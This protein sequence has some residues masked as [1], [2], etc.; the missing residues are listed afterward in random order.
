MG[1]YPG[2]VGYL[3][4]CQDSEFLLP[5][6]VLEDVRTGWSGTPLRYGVAAWALNSL[7]PLGIPTASINQSNVRDTSA[8]SPYDTCLDPRATPQLSPE[9]EVQTFRPLSRLSAPAIPSTPA[10]NRTD[11]HLPN[12]LEH[13]QTLDLIGKLGTKH[14]THSCQCSLDNPTQCTR[15]S[16][17]AP[18]YNI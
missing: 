3:F 6:L 4:K 16:G 14:F 9:H 15:R 17:P 7:L 2:H 11:P 10:F 1:R 18:P 8:T 13:W 5:R 12:I